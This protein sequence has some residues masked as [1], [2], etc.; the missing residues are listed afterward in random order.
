LLSGWTV[1]L[2][3]GIINSKSYWGIYSSKRL[4]RILRVKGKAFTLI[5]LKIL[6]E[7]VK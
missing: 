4:K 5:I 6:G 1:G 3:R 7:L 2:I